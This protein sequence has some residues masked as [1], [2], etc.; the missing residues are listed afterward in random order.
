[1]PR[2][3]IYMRVECPAA[4]VPGSMRQT[5][6]WPARFFVPTNMREKA[7]VEGPSFPVPSTEL[8]FDRFR[9]Q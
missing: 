7:A 9:L 6:G 4:F 2:A 3:A 1:M 8:V 5:G